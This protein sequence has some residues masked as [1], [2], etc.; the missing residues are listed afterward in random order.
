[1]SFSRLSKF[2]HI[3]P[4]SLFIALQDSDSESSTILWTIFDIFPSPDLEY[5]FIISEAALQRIS[6]CSKLSRFFF[7]YILTMCLDILSANVLLA[8]FLSVPSPP[9][10]TDLLRAL[11]RE[12]QTVKCKLFRS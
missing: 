7:L 6:I 5:I 1:M 11:R 3:S 8:S 12:T 9:S 4:K 2:R 10:H